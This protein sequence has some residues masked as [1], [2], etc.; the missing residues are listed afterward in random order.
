MENNNL[1]Y[2]KDSYTQLKVDKSILKNI[3][4]HTY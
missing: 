2:N 3:I 1:N 4:L